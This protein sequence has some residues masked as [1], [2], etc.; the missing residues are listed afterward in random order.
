MLAVSSSNQITASWCTYLESLPVTIATSPN[1]EMQ[2]LEAK[3]I[4]DWLTQSHSHT[5]TST[6]M[7]PVDSVLDRLLSSMPYMEMKYLHYQLM[8]E[9]MSRAM[10][11]WPKK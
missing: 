9:G 7:S 3:F 4:L 6:G 8:S 2:S 1:K 11:V 10:G 5:E